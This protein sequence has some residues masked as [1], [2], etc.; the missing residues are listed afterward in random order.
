MIV[1]VLVDMYQ[2]THFWFEY[3]TFQI[4]K[5]SSIIQTLSSWSVHLMQDVILKYRFLEFFRFSKKWDF[6]ASIKWDICFIKMIV[7]EVTINISHHYFKIWKY[8]F[9]VLTTRWMQKCQKIAKFC[10]IFFWDYLS[11]RY[12]LQI[13]VIDF[14][15]WRHWMK[16][17]CN[18]IL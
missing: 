15:I 16:I 9:I 13:V 8:L 5:T 11:H 12:W 3:C 7:S 14:T 1:F 6:N 17:E 4:L 10:L 18:K 2:M